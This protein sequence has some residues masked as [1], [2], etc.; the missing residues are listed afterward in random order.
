MSR[1]PDDRRPPVRQQSRPAPAKKKPAPAARPQQPRSSQSR[2]AQSRPQ[3][4]RP[5]VKKAAPQQTRKPQPARKPPQKTKAPQRRYGS[6]VLF[7]WAAL[8]FPELVLHL[9]T[10]KSGDLMMNSGLV[11]GPVFAILPA[12][13]L[14][15]VCTSKLSICS[16]V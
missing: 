6:L 16:G 1:Y 14:F 9:S 7:L 10:A 12:C 8:A 3:Q 5:P 2:P 11:L 13:I 4:S 15:A